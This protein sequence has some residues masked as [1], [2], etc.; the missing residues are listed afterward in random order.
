MKEDIIQYDKI[1][2]RQDEDVEKFFDRIHLEI[3]L[4]AMI[5]AGFPNEGYIEFKA[6]DLYHRK[7]NIITRAGKT[8]PNY[9]CGL[10][11][12]SPLSCMVDN[13]VILLKHKALQINPE[14]E[15]RL[16]ANEDNNRGGN[17]YEFEK[18]KR[19]QWKIKL[20]HKAT[21]TIISDMF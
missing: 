5:I 8:S 10:P 19:T 6:E 18:G 1:A 3:Q 9:T 4:A 11:Q 14:D 12:G 13:L 7:Y 17:G 15:T 2:A 20:Y 21:Q 16:T